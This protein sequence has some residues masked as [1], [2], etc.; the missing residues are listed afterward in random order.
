MQACT[1]AQPVWRRNRQWSGVMGERAGCS[2]KKAVRQGN[3]MLFFT[4][5]IRKAQKRGT[6]FL[7][8]SVTSAQVH[9]LHPSLDA[10]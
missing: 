7:F 5:V 2:R 9:V 1:A 8:F 6:T 10:V 3:K 4:A